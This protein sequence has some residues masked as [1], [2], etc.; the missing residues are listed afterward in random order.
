MPRTVDPERHE[1]RRLQIIDAGL[2]CFA[3][4]GY[5]GATTAA[6]CREAGIGSGTFFHY[7][8]SKVELLLAILALG[9]HET[10]GWFASQLGRTDPLAV[11]GDYVAHAADELADPRLPGFV[12]AVGA[13]MTEPQVAQ[14]LARDDEVVRGGLR[15]WV[16]AAQRA[17]TLRDDLS[18]ERLTE[19]VLAIID[20][21]IGRLAT[22]TDFDA[23]TE[24]LV[25]LDAVN[26]I[27]EP[28][29]V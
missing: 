23:V 5:D 25:L 3:R 14:A 16:A 13:V 9:S 18:P 28:P 26:R 6:I 17:G 1:A 8:P 21:F 20:G 4:H 24:R 10:A 27:L 2:T 12:R 11:I 7:F 29:P 22:A 15:P 19:W